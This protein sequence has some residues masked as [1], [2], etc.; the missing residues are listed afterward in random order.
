MSVL[1][2]LFILTVIGCLTLIDYRYKLVYFA[3]QRQAIK[4]IAIAV[5]LFIVWDVL[6]ILLQ[7]FYIGSSQYLL[8]L[9]I[10]QFPLEE[11]GFLTVLCYQALLIFTF[12]QK[13]GQAEK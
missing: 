8:G 1:Y 3:R 7:I 9:R 10:G 13:R 2:L 4:T 6:G 11:L 12:L 5:T